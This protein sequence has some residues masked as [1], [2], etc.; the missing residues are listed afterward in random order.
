MPITGKLNGSQAAASPSTALP[1][2]PSPPRA[3]LSF[4]SP[5]AS[6]GS[7]PRAIQRIL[8][9]CWKQLF[10]PLWKHGLCLIIKPS[11]AG[12]KCTAAWVLGIMEL[13]SEPLTTCH[14][15]L[16]FT[17]SK[18]T[19][20]TISSLGWACVSPW[21]G[22]GAGGD[23]RR[24]GWVSPSWHPGLRLQPLTTQHWV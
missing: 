8:C 11:E 4:L 22:K 17:C 19:E 15:L 1:L 6:W 16:I 12:S 2:P 24:T 3:G 18:P 20:N 23:R 21:R 13:P 9:L 7:G 5:N 14:L 10:S